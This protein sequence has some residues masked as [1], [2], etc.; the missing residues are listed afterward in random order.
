VP[1]RADHGWWPYWGPFFGFLLLVELGGRLPESAQGVWL[2]LKVALPG[3]LF[4][5]FWRDGRYPELRG[6]DVGAAGLA[7]DVGVGLLGAFLWVAPFLVFDGMRPDAEGFDPAQLGEGRAWLALS[8]R[9][10]GYAGVTPFVEELFMR[11][12]LLRFLDTKA[13]TSIPS[14]RRFV[15]RERSFRDFRDVPI[16]HFS[17]LSFS[18][19][20]LFFLASHQ[21]WEW[22]V[23]LVWTVGTM[24]WLYRRRR[25]MSLVVVHAVTNG[26]ILL[27]V[28]WGDGRF[29]DAEG[30]PISLWFFV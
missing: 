26:A 8:V 22:P 5:W 15:D 19:V 10:V 21:P 13:F 20:T 9:F 16:G 3:L 24:L 1:K 12:W 18:L 30:S 25:L 6:Y 17:W 28:I 7:A 4:L 14:V 23:M 11:S 2:V 27:F 29:L